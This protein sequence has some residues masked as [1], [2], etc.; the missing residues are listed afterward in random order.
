E[1][2]MNRRQHLARHARILTAPTVPHGTNRGQLSP[3]IGSLFLHSP[4]KTPEPESCSLLQ[5]GLERGAVMQ[6]IRKSSRAE[7]G[8]ARPI[9]AFRMRS[10]MDGSWFECLSNGVASIANPGGAVF[11]CA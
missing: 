4:D 3:D 6:G 7:S 8:D 5:S 11:S 2:P 1:Q 9:H 10:W